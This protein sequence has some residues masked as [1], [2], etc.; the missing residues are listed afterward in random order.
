MALCKPGGEAS[1][2]TNHT[3]TLIS[4]FQPAELGDNKNKCLL[5]KPPSR[6]YS[7]WQPEMTNIHCKKTVFMRPSVR[8][9]FFL[10]QHL[11]FPWE[12][13]LNCYITLCSSS[14]DNL[15]L[16]FP[17]PTHELGL[18]NQSICSLDQPIQSLGFL[19]DS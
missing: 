6:W 8:S 5:F 2:E 4:D 7:V 13:H 17:G 3:C 11:D 10:W 1:S 14:S 12:S 19:L 9:P 16:S 18:A 15:T